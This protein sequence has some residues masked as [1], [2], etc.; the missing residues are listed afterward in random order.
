MKEFLY[1]ILI[2]ITLTTLLIA[3]TALIAV[4]SYAI[5]KDI[6]KD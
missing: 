5:I 1:E 3:V 4:F 6:I 2:P